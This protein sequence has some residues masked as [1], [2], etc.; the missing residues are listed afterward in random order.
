MWV[1]HLPV[2]FS[3]W[4]FG[5][6]RHSARGETGMPVTKPAGLEVCGDRECLSSKRFAPG[7]FFLPGPGGFF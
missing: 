6:H 2:S 7:A 1:F 3:G 5:C 4:V